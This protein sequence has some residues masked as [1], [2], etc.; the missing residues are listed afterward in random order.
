VQ[1]NSAREALIDILP[2]RF[3]SPLDLQQVVAFST[4]V[5]TVK[6]GREQGKHTDSP[7]LCAVPE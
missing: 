6:L 3:F 5:A 1:I 2:W 4:G 7:F